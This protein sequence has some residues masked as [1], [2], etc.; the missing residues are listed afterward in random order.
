MDH[1][2]T[3]QAEHVAMFEAIEASDKEGARRAMRTHIQNACARVFEGPDAAVE[4]LGT[5]TARDG[6]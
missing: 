3:V 1:L 2:L 5:L 4:Q 6:I